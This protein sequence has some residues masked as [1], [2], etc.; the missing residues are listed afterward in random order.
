MAGTTSRRPLDRVG[1]IKVKIGVLVGLSV[2]AAALVAEIGNRADV[3]VW[4][5]LPVTVAAALAVTQWLARGMTAPLREMTAAAAR[6]ATGDYAQRVTDTSADEVGHLARAF[7]TMAVDLATADQQR[8]R[9]VATVSHEL[10]TPLAAQRALLENLVDGVVRPD[11]D[12]LQAA[13]AQ[14]ER[15]SDLVGD[16]LDIA[17][18][19]GGAVTLDLA[20]LPAADLLA[21]AVAEARLGARGVRYR[22]EV[23][24]P[25]LTVSGDAARL[26]QVV[27][28][29]LDNAAR[30]S[31]AG[32]T[33]TVRAAAEAP[34]RWTLEVI[35]EGPGLPAG[36]EADVTARFGATAGDGGGGTG[37]GLAIAGWVCELHGGS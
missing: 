28:N 21:E 2:V 7:N 24:P 5:T 14:S 35:D 27:A 22:T 30:H 10:R 15:L 33:V 36:L 37:L 18:V 4:L 19:D 11:D 25:D 23:S 6:M 12:A 29:L 1:S 13:L 20:P 26:A 32:G 8:R 34:D 3:P 31:P 16:L 17:R 9:L